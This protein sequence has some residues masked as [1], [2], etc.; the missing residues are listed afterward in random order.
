LTPP[1]R[2]PRI[3][4]ESPSI[5]RRRTAQRHACQSLFWGVAA[6]VVLQ[7]GLRLAIDCRC[8]EMRDPTFE[9]RV[10]QLR[11]IIAQS[12]QPPDLVF[13][14]GSSVTI[15]AFKARNV[16]DLLKQELDRPFVVA[17]MA[18]YGGGP[19]TELMWTRRLLARGLKPRLMLIEFSLQAYAHDLPIDAARFPSHLLDAADLDV[20]ERYGPEEN[21]RQNWWK[22]QLVP[23]YGHRLTMLSYLA[24][25]LVP[26]ADEV[27]MI[28]DRLDER[29]WVEETTPTPEQ[30]Q[31]ALAKL[32]AQEAP[33]FILG[34]HP[35]NAIR[36]LLE[37]LDREKIPA[38]VVMAPWSPATRRRASAEVVSRLSGQIAELSRKNG[39]QFVS[40]FDWLPE[41]T[42]FSDC[43]HVT[44]AGAEI[45]TQRLAREVVLPELA[46]ARRAKGDVASR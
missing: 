38:V 44:N 28:A 40:A 8:P 34:K 39:C 20:M 14:V 33:T 17:N 4:K 1:S 41:E 27:A 18:N 29:F 10:S 36:E 15:G 25:P 23:S 19:L 13:M 5:D 31:S 26:R 32:N 7:A 12:D 35:L 3:E 46:T 30:R 22:T 43:L 24:K 42:L 45:F 9:V 11:Q 6:F 37:L 21:L 2:R 16:E